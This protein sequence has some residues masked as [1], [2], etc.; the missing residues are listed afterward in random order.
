MILKTNNELAYMIDRETCGAAKVY[1]DGETVS[2]HWHGAQQAQIDRL[3]VLIADYIGR[4][5]LVGSYT[6]IKFYF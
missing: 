1:L 5:M 6:Q 4:H 2:V 3:K